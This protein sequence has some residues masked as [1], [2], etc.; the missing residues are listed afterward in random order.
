MSELRRDV[1]AIVLKRWREALGVHDAGPDDDFF[2]LGGD[3][4]VATR[5]VALLRA[6]L[7]IAV[8]LLAVFDHPTAAELALELEQARA[9]ATR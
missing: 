3:S 9:G 6:E 2:E 7:G 5:L 1:P 8:S 4:L